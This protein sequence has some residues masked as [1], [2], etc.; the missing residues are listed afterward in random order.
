[1]AITTDISMSRSGCIPPNSRSIR[2][3]ARSGAR[4]S[5]SAKRCSNSGSS[6]LPSSRSKSSCRPSSSLRNAVRTWSG[7]RLSASQKAL[8][9]SKMFEVSTPPKSTSNP[10]LAVTERHLL[11]APRQLDDTLAEAAQERVVG[12][13]RGR[14]LVV[15]LHED[16]RLPQR[17]RAVPAHVAHRAAAALLVARDQLVA[18]RKALGARDRAELEGPERR[19]GGLDPQ[20]AQVAHVG[21]R[22][23][24]RAHLPVEDRAQ[25][26]R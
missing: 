1:M 5:S 3:S 20:G 18:G 15:A 17:E 9:D 19:V 22:V 21:Q 24:D 2:P 10:V 4:P 23:A 12:R 13:A 26:R 25:A 8:N 16:D 14:A 7:V 11:R 6:S